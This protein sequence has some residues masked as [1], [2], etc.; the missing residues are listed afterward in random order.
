MTRYIVFALVVVLSVL[1]LEASETEKGRRLADL[2]E[3]LTSPRRRAALVGLAVLM[4]L[5]GLALAGTFGD[6]ARTVVGAVQLVAFLIAI[7]LV[8]VPGTRR[9]LREFRRGWDEAESDRRHA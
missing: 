3:R 7:P 1:A 2:R 8:F 4:S 9:F 5:G 6:P